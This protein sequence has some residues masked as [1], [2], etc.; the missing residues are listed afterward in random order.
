MEE[1]P[2]VYS[3]ILERPWLKQHKAIMIGVTTF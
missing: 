3:M 2:E 1:T